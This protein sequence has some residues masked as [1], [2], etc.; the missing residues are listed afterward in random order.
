LAGFGKRRIAGVEYDLTHL[1]S[2]VMSVTATYAGAP[3]YR[4]RVVF[5]AHTFTRD[6]ISTDTPDFHYRDGGTTRCF[7]PRRHS[8]SLHLPG[9]IRAASN[10][11]A[12]FGNKDMKYLLVEAIPGLNAP[13]VVA[14]TIR[15]RLTKRAHA[16][17]VIVSAHDRPNL[18]TNLPTIAL[19]TLVSL[20]MQDLPIERPKK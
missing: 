15:K 13:Y 3:T 11:D 5:G 4:V 9:L 10:G 1:D 14:F 17:M 8:Y 18:P 6:L 16:T 19:G 12:Y 20:T 2:F 7:C